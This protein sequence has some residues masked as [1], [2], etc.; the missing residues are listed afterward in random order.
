[1]MKDKISNESG[2][3]GVGSII[4]LAAIIVFVIFPITAFVFDNL[5]IQAIASEVS[6]SIDSAVVDTYQSLGFPFLSQ[7]DF[8]A[9]NGLFQYYIEE[10]IKKDLKL[11]AD[12]TPKADSILDGP[13]TINSFKFIDSTQLPYTDTDSGKV[14][15]RPFIEIDFTIRVKPTLYQEIILDALGKP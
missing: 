15:N 4:L 6:K 2:E 7:E 14:Y 11:N 13:F 12:L 9:D 1:M 10:R 3:G 8:R 5:K